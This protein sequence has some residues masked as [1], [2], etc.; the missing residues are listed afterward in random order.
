M[1]HEFDKHNKKHCIMK[2]IS[3]VLATFLGAFLAFYVVVD[4]TIKNL[5]DPMRQMKKFDK[6]IEQQDREMMKMEKRFRKSTLTPFHKPIVSVDENQNE[7]VIVVNLKPFD[8]KKENVKITT[9][10]DLITI[11]GEVEKNKNNEERIMSFSQTFNLDEDAKI[12]ALQKKVVKDKYI[13]TVPKK[14]DD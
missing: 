10:D 4:S 9:K 14:V 3:I 12:S 8:N 7:Y 1:E 6:M 5:T 11:T 13:I 2:F